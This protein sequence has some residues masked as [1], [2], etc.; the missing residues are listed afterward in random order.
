VYFEQRS[1]K[2]N[3]VTKKKYLG[4]LAPETNQIIPCKTRK[5]RLKDIE[6]NKTEN[7][8]TK[9]NKPDETYKINL[10]K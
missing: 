10:S 7:I 5:E 6:K 9:N 3:A 1:C 2:K 8:D 4:R